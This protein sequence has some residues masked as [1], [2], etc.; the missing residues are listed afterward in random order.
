MESTPQRQAADWSA[1]AEDAQRALLERPRVSIRTRLTVAFVLWFLLTLG[2]AIVSM[3]TLSQMANKLRFTEAVDHYTF[4][5]QQARRF[6]KNYF[7]YHTNLTDAL[8]HVHNA[9]AVLDRERSNI[10]A[11]IEDSGFQSMRLNLRRYEELLARL[12]ILDR[13]PEAEAA[14][15]YQATEAGLRELGAIMVAEAEDLVQG[16]R[17]AVDRML[18]LSQR[19][20]LGIL[21]LLIG[22]ITYTAVVIR[23]QV[24]A[25]LNRMMKTTNRI[26]E[27]DFTPITPVR[28]YYD[29]FSHLAVA[30]NAMMIQLA[31]RHSLLVQAHKL[32]AVGTLTAGVAHELNNPINNIMLTASGLQEDYD[33]LTVDERLDMVNDLV[34]ESERAQRI[35]RNLLDF[36]RESSVNLQPI[37]PQRLIE[38]TLRLATNQ[39]KL[40]KVKVRGEI[41]ANLPAI[42]G[43]F[44]QLSQ[45]LLNIV[46]NAL[47]AMPDGGVLS[48]S[49]RNPRGGDKIAMEFTDT[50]TG[51]S[52][53]VLANVFD[54]F[55]TTK[56][57]AKGTGLG[58]SVSQGIIRQHG[59]DILA[60][61]TP[62]EG[63]TFT[64]ELPVAMVPAA[65]AGGEPEDADEA[66]IR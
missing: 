50:G 23:Q 28:R 6:E 9:Q 35:V 18:A 34:S 5:I 39:I 7:L 4:E 40:A 13:L 37:D 61:S 51:M 36:A 49:V 10:E 47:D 65:Q 19:I 33:E 26:A 21:V 38:E 62:G 22:V 58:L 24:L 3:V 27:G 57:G 2:L 11:V 30:M 63:T 15:E 42:H 53:Q 60:R 12:Q 25:P 8:D 17:V 52:E 59:G 1:R 44:Q 41:D 29:E 45:V 48:I 46:M 55:F 14:A 20:P 66:L 32:K 64:V 43:D 16:E 54:P 56:S 31:H